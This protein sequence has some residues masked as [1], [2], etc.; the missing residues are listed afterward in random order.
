MH[1]AAS[2][3]LDR[4]RQVRWHKES[5]Q[6]FEQLTEHEELVSLGTRDG[7]GLWTTQTYRETERQPWNTS[8]TARWIDAG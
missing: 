4:R 3:A 8:R 7:E 6:L 5:V 2:A 1:G